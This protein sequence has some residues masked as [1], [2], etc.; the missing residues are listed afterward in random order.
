MW[1]LI[2]GLTTIKEGQEDLFEG[3]KNEEEE[4]NEKDEEGEKEKEETTME[5]TQG[6]GV[7]DEE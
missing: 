1:K 6:E 3:R 4:E 2:Y 7:T 5:K